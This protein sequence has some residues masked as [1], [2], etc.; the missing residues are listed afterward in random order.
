[1]RSTDSATPRIDST[2]APTTA[3]TVI[4]CVYNGASSSIQITDTAP[5]TGSI[6]THNPSALSLQGSF[7]VGFNL[8]AKIAYA[9]AWNQ[10][11]ITNEIAR[12]KTRYG[13]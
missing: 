7:S 1:M 6:S 11:Q 4:A 13:L 10:T 9:S 5:V 12:L 2:V 3:A 8:Y